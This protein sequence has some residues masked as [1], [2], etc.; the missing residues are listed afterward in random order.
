MNAKRKM[1]ACGV[2]VDKADHIKWWDALDLLWI[3]ETAKA[4][5]LARSSKHPDAQWLVGLFANCGASFDERFLEVFA[6]YPDDPRVLHLSF[7]VA[8]DGVPDLA[9]LRR[10][11]EL[12][13]APAQSLLSLECADGEE[14]LSWERLWGSV[15]DWPSWGGSFCRRLAEH[16]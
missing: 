15:V 6:E 4:M 16:T 8:L 2:V 7:V 12:G 5:E 11:A 3:G 9:S 14:S 13:Y 1:Q 10:A